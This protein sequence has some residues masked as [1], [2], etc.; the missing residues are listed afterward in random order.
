VALSPLAVA[1]VMQPS[2]LHALDY[3]LLASTSLTDFRRRVQRYFRLVSQTARI[4]IVKRGAEVHFRSVP[5][6]VVSPQ[7]QDAWLGTM[8]HLM[9]R[10][11]RDDFRPLAVEV[12]HA[13]LGPG[14]DAYIRFFGAPARFDRDAATLVLARANM[15]VP[16][17][18]A[19][20][21]LAQVN[22]NLAASY[23]ARLDRSDTVANVLACIVEQLPSGKCSRSTVA[24]ALCMSPSR[25]RQRLVERG[26][27]FHELLNDIRRELACGYLRQSGVS[28]TAITF[29]LGFS[30][31]T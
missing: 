26:T 11:Y 19:C 17:H 27:T 10:L 7:S 29:L 23:M 18:G 9:R 28:V 25:L 1:T 22:D 14:S 3:G 16:L 4:E 13:M 21:E 24:A 30:D 8:Y 2:T 20:P 31:V 5:L 12:T 6:V 15:D